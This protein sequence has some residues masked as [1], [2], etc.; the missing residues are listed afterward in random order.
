MLYSRVDAMIAL[1]MRANGHSREAVAE[2]IRENPKGRD[3]QRYAER[4]VDYAF[5]YSHRNYH[6]YRLYMHMMQAIYT[7]IRCIPYVKTYR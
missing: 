6:M 7:K 1:R 2:A 5:G 3:W 4:T